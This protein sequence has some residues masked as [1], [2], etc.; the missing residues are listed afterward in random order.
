MIVIKFIHCVR[1]YNN[2]KFIKKNTIY[3]M[4]VISF[5]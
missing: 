2:C 5:K 4:I 1:F 3:A